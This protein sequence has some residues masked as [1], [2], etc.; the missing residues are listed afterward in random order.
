MEIEQSD[1]ESANTV[2]KSY[3]RRRNNLRYL[4]K[5]STFEPKKKTNC[6]NCG[7]EFP[8]ASKCPAV[9]KTCNFCRKMNP[10]AK[11]CRSKRGRQNTNNNARVNNL[12]NNESEIAYSDTPDSNSDDDYVFGLREATVNK[13]QKGQ[14]KM[15]VKINNSNVNFLIYTGW[16][17]NILDENTFKKIGS[18][19]KLS[20]SNK[21]VFAYGSDKT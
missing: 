10:F 12:G 13:V 16:S 5:Q 4:Q 15:T 14:P 18:K 7:G 21:R 11:V 17:F 19:P 20:H 8:H 1:K 3:P 6:G 9:G 2:R